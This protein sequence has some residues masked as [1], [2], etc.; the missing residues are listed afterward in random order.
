ML[1]GKAEMFDHAAAVTTQHAETV[2]VVDQQSGL[3]CVRQPR[4]LRQRRHIAVHTEY[5]VADD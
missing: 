5:A 2:G 1:G 3:A 4:Q